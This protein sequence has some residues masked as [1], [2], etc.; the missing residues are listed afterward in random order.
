MSGSRV[1][2]VE[3]DILR[4]RRR[5]GTFAR[6]EREELGIYRGEVRAIMIALAEIIARLDTI[7]AYI[8]GDDGEEETES[9]DA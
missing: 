3:T 6:M 1:E 9:P 4:E 2:V 7:L 8:E 5:V